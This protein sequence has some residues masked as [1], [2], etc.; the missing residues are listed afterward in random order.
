LPAADMELIRIGTPLHDIGKIGI[1]ETILRKPDRLTPEEFDQ[2]KL[3]TIKGD[4]LISTLPE[5]H[6]IRPIVRSHHERWD[7][8]GDPDGLK[9]EAIALVARIVAVADAFDAMTSDRPYRKG[10][11]ATVAFGEIEKNLGKQFDPR[12]GGGFLAIRERILQ[13]MRNQV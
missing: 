6:P 4:D 12:C 2:M 13:D 1:D 5:L 11:A 3:H 10:M 9:G 8:H 7:G